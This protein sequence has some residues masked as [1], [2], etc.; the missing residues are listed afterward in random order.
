MRDDSNISF[1]HVAAD[2]VVWRSLRHSRHPRKPA[3]LIRVASETLPPEIRHSFGW[4]WLNVWIMTRQTTQF[5]ATFAKAAADFHSG[6]VFKKIRILL[7]PGFRRNF[8][9]SD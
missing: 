9:D 1:G 3:A 7:S 6:V 5:C 8:E 4:G 2:A